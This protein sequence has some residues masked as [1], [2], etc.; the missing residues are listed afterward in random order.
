MLNKNIAS[1]LLK[2]SVYNVLLSGVQQSDLAVHTY[3]CI[4]KS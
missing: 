3:T 1:F 2:L 4:N